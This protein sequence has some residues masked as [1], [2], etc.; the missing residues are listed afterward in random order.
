LKFRY[1]AIMGLK[2]RWFTQKPDN[3][4]VPGSTEGEITNETGDKKE[5]A[6]GLSHTAESSSDGEIGGAQPERVS[7]EVQEGVQKAE[8]ITLTWSKSTLYLV[9]CL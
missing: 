2:D 1:F 4:V 9:F 6:R 7:S 5:I 8:A 3:S